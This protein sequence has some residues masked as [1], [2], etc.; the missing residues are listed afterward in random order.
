[1]TL[2][3]LAHHFLVRLRSRLADRA[4]ALTVLQARVLLASVLPKREFDAQAAIELARQVQRQNHAAYLS[5]PKHTIQRLD[6]G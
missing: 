2:T 4:S 6:T 3:I 1:M 5:H